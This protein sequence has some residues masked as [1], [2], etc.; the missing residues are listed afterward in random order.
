MFIV[1]C[2]AKAVI[3]EVTASSS[4]CHLLSS[5][6]ISRGCIVKKYVIT[7]IN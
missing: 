5:S 7:T 4:P 1:Y 3:M 6:C 2:R